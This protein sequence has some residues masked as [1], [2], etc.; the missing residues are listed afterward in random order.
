MTDDEKAIYWQG[1][2]KGV[3]QSKKAGQSNDNEQPDFVDIAPP[4][5]ND[6]ALDELV[7]SMLRGSWH[8]GRICLE[9]PSKKEIAF[10]TARILALITTREAQ[11][12]ERGQA[13]ELKYLA[14]HGH[15]GGNWRRLIEIRK[16]KS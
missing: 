10:Y 11:A 3:E 6:T 9:A 8:S 12:Y 5:V 14:T 1:F 4:D 13:D 2:N 7:T 15:G 16:G